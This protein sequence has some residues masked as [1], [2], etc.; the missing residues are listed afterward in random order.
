MARDG[1][2]GLALAVAA[3][4][5][6]VGGTVG[7]LLIVTLAAPLAVLAARFTA[8][9]H[10]ALMCCGLVAAVVMA[11]GSALKAVAMVGAGLSLGAVGTDVVTGQARW[12]LG[13]PELF[14]G[15]GFM[16]LAIGLFGLADVIA[17]LAAPTDRAPVA[18][19]IDRV[20]P[21][22]GEVRRA[23]AATSR[24]TLLGSVLGI[25]PG[26]GPVI[27]SFASYAVERRLAPAE[28]P[29]G[30]GA[31]EGIAGPESA[32]NAAAQTSF[33]PLL[34]LGLPSNPVMALMLSALV[35]HGIQPGPEILSK[36]PA[37]FWGLVA[38]MW[39]GNL[40]LLVLNLPLVG[41]WARLLRVPYAVLYPTTL[42]L[43]CIGVYSLNHSTFDL[44]LMAAF[45]VAG[46]L[47]RT[48][49]FEPAPLLLAF[50]LSRPLEENMRRALVFS[51]GDV[52]VFV[53]E[54]ISAVLLAVAVAAL[55]LTTLPAI[56]RR[57]ALLQ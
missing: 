23:I 20:R 49:D 24:G 18:G 46:Y 15:I 57:R 34:A 29:A 19:R 44:W 56:Q 8:A 31:I 16:P 48:R 28:Q 21:V 42:V 3:I 30:S 22:R 35:V 45:G 13:V 5:S 1:R 26:G 53:K 38:S 54:P 37:L 9:D 41:L 6:F 50:V 33:I 10:A 17:V 40:L 7:T 32:N 11:S 27:A 12:T 14:D 2:A 51:N 52:T 25:L 55:L 36:E 47:L 39:I 4:S 43:S